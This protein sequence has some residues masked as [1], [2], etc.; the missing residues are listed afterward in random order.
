MA[1]RIQN[2]EKHDNSRIDCAV[3]N[4]Q[5]LTELFFIERI[6]NNDFEIVNALSGFCFDEE[7]GEIHLKRGKQAKDQLFWI[8]KAPVQGFYTYWWI[9]TSKSSDKAVT[10]EGLLRYKNFDL[11]DE[12]Q[13]FRFEPINNNNAV[14]STTMI[15]NSRSGKAI[16]VPRGVSDPG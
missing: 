3:P 15:V 6:D 13:L 5:D 10:L 1:L 11:N 16:D 12:T 2:L 8:E 9:K 14:L 7:S 4:P